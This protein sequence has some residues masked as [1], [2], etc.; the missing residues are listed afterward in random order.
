MTD[1]QR[2]YQWRHPKYIRVFSSRVLVDPITVENPKDVV[3]WS[4]LT[5]RCQQSY[6]TEARTH[7]LFQKEDA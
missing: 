4:C 6:E 2:L 1:G 3:P 5:E 7:Y